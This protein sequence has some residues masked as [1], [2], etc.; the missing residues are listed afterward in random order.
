M[1]Q[2]K[3]KTEFGSAT[4]FDPQALKMASKKKTTKFAKPNRNLKAFCHTVLQNNPWKGVIRTRCKVARDL[5][6]D[7]VID[8]IKN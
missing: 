6:K 2:C 8:K 1:Q 3:I 4:I 7:L 5:A